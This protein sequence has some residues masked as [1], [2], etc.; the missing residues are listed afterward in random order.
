VLISADPERGRSDLRSSTLNVLDWLNKPVDL[1]HLVRV[2]TRAVAAWAG[3]IL[4]KSRTS[5]DKLIAILRRVVADKA[6]HAPPHFTLSLPLQ[7]LSK[8]VA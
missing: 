1:D 3:A 2:I 5:I 8:E 6:G 4:T 7:P